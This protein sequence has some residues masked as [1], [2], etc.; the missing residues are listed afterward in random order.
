MYIKWSDGNKNASFSFLI[1]NLFLPNL[2]FLLIFLLPINLIL[3]GFISS[4][5]YSILSYL[6]FLLLTL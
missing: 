2:T 5:L 4:P 6:A 1:P 3:L